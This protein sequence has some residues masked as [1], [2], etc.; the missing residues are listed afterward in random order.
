MFGGN[1]ETRSEKADYLINGRN[2]PTRGYMLLVIA[3][4]SWSK[5]R[6]VCHARLSGLQFL[7]EVIDIFTDH[8]L[9]AR[10]RFYCIACFTVGNVTGTESPGLFRC[11][12][13]FTHALILS[14][15]LVLVKDA[16]FA[17]FPAE[18]SRPCRCLS[19]QRFYISGLGIMRSL[20]ITTR[21]SVALQ[22]CRSVRRVAPNP[23]NS[24][25]D[26]PFSS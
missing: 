20:M 25:A 16:P 19:S 12:H 22:N 3:P 9:P 7:Q 24:A 23:S 5:D 14:Q 10:K 6:G 8:S 2:V 26:I 18:S 4:E 15:L 21:S 1:V 11:L 17:P 13:D